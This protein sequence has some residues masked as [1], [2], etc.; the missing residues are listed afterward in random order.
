MGHGT[1]VDGVQRLVTAGFDLVSG[2]QRKQKKGFALVDGVQRDIG[3]AKM[4]TV[5]LTGTGWN[6]SP[7]YITI[8]GVKYSAAQTIEVPE[9][10]E[11]YCRVIN[12][13]GAGAGSIALNGVGVATEEPG[14][15]SGG[16]SAWLYTHVVASDLTIAGLTSGA[17]GRTMEITTE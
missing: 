5:T 17:I 9:G 15:A 7:C 16:Y 2:V 4:F 11:I 13:T 6:A 12:N 14:T 10:A 1:M 8:D 3:F